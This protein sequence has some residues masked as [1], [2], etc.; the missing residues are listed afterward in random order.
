[1]LRAAVLTM[2]PGGYVR[3]GQLWFVHGAWGL[4]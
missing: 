4:C 1:V 2:E 3:A